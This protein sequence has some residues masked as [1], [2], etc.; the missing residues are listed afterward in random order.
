ME[1]LKQE[2][3]KFIECYNSRR[4]HEALGNVTP[5]GTY[6]N[7]TRLDRFGRKFGHRFRKYL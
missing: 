2:I 4:Y 5:D 6:F 7:R 3:S 1:E